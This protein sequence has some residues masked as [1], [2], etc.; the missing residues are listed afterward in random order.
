MD[1]P[2]HVDFS[3]EVSSALRLSDGAV[4]LVDVVEGVSAQTHTVLRQAFEEKVKTCLVLNKLDKL[5]I[6]GHMDALEIYLHLN[7]IIEQVNSIVAELISKD[8]LGQATPSQ[9]QEGG[10]DTSGGDDGA[11]EDALE[12][13][14]N[15]LFFCPEKG[16]VAFSSAMDCWAFNLTIFARKLAAKFGMNPRVL[17]KFL[18]GEYYYSE[19][20]VFRQPRHDRHRPMFVQFVLDPLLAEYRKHFDVIDSSQAGEVKEARIKVKAQFTKWMPMEKGILGMVV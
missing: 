11:D 5:M 1:S 6:D 13:K 14:E 17:Q 3:S 9:D 7:Q 18:W 15:E 20:K 4:V 12:Q 19:K 8:Y 10:V 16:N 2:G